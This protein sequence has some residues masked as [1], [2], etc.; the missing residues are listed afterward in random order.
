LLIAFIGC[1]T[2]AP[3][4]CKE[5]PAS[6]L[7]RVIAVIILSLGNATREIQNGQKERCKKTQHGDG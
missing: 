6:A 3:A 4:S 5:K 1:D 7:K 2:I